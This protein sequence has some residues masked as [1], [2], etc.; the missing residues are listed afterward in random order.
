M[1]MSFPVIRFL[2]TAYA[3]K[4]PFFVHIFM[5]SGLREMNVLSFQELLYKTMA[6]TA[7]AFVIDVA[8][9]ITNLFLALMIVSLRM[10]QIVVIS[11]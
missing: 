8:N 4:M 11:V 9:G 10:L 5:N 3:V 7:V 1:R 2:A 6:Y